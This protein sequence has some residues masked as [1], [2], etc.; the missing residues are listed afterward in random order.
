LYRLII[1]IAIPYPRPAFTMKSYRKYYE[2]L[3]LAP[4]CSWEDLR[5]TYRRL[6]KTWHPDRFA[7]GDR[8]RAVAQERIKTITS[9]F[10]KLSD[11][12]RRHGCLPQEPDA[13]PEPAAR[14]TSETAAPSEWPAPAPPVAADIAL[15]P[16]PL[17]VTL[18]L[19]IIAGVTFL[20]V[21]TSEDLPD[22]TTSPE[23]A[24]V[25]DDAPARAPEHPPKPTKF[26]T[27][28][29]SLGD[30]H[31]AQGTPTRAEPGVWYYGN[32]RVYFENGRVTRWEHDPLTLLNAKVILNPE[33]STPYF[34]I[35]STRKQVRAIQGAPN[36]QFANHWEY[37]AS[38]V[39]FSGDRVVGW[40]EATRGELRVPH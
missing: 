23:P 2:A 38:R 36:N 10:Q 20:L 21:V 8:T 37:G 27:I 22:T 11:Y 29:S 15:R 7:E 25:P 19:A 33:D 32:A 35:G 3:G 17:L 30:V 9:A 4:G 13:R 39:Y 12:H 31:E 34:T 40:Y 28:G 26:F 16:R 5:T 6:V 14:A 24:P 1:T 18:T